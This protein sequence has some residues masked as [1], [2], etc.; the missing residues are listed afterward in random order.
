MNYSNNGRQQAPNRV[1]FIVILLSMALFFS[2]MLYL[3]I[4]HDGNI[5]GE[6]MSV[7][8]YDECE[9]VIVTRPG[10]YGSAIGLAHKGNC[11]FCAQRKLA[12][13]P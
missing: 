12:E 13:Q 2:A 4:D 7:V 1:V 8:T 10:V 9:Y 6:S 5:T 11:K 3:K